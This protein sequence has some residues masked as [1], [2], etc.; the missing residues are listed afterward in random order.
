MSP[1]PV[2]AKTRSVEKRRGHLND[3]DMFLFEWNVNEEQGKGN[4]FYAYVG[5]IMLIMGESE[6]IKTLWAILNLN[7]EHLFE[8]H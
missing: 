8:D 4:Y 5:K 3:F 1:V 2:Q 6:S 7:Y